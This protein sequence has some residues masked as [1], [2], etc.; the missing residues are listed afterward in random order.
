MISKQKQVVLDT[1]SSE[2]KAIQLG[3]LPPNTTGHTQS[4]YVIIQKLNCVNL[5]NRIHKLKLTNAYNMIHVW[6]FQV[7]SSLADCEISTVFPLQIQ[8]VLSII[9]S[10]KNKKRRK[11]YH[12]FSIEYI[13][14]KKRFN[15]I[16]ISYTTAQ[17]VLSQAEI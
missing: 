6:R 16:T 7:L 3:F 2:L 8:P 14:R 13:N 4:N 5:S 10:Q 11:K 12:L 15:F 17:S 9:F 1:D